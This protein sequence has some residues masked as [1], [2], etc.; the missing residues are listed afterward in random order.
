MFGLFKKQPQQTPLE[1]KIEGLCVTIPT[2]ILGQYSGLKGLSQTTDEAKKWMAY[3]YIYGVTDMAYQGAQIN[4]KAI[5]REIVFFVFS[6]VLAP[7]LPNFF[8]ICTPDE[9]RNVVIA[10]SRKLDQNDP[11][12]LAGIHAGAEDY[13]RFVI[14]DGRVMTGLMELFRS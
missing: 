3:G 10:V 11:D 5:F 7:E 13:R 8:K 4:D 6:Q 14:H 2:L 9:S 12:V 1:K